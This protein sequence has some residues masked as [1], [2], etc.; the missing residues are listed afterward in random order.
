MKVNTSPM[1]RN[2]HM[3]PCSTINNK[4]SKAT[5]NHTMLGT[6]PPARSLH[7]NNGGKK[8]MFLKHLPCSKNKEHPCVFLTRLCRCQ[9]LG[10]CRMGSSY[11][12]GR[13]KSSDVFIIAESNAVGYTFLE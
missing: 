11:M 6:E 12:K 4:V 3:C 10:I 2:L 7:R 8:H 9:T 5:G 1:T 13:V